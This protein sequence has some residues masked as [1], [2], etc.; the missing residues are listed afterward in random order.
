MPQAV[1]LRYCDGASLSGDKPTP[2]VFQNTTLHF[3]GRAILDAQIKSLLTERGM[4]KASDVVVSGCSAGGL[5]T[6]LHC[7]H[8]AAAIAKATN[9]GGNAGAKVVCMPDAGF[10]LDEDRVPA[11]G[12][13]VLL[14]PSNT[15]AL[16][17]MLGTCNAGLSLVRLASLDNCPFLAA[18]P[19]PAFI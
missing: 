7:D 19:P 13:K 5:A 10:F 14:P 15:V 12:A 8:W 3:R 1:F 6:F 17:A 18:L 4:D 9:N 2:T 11:Y 16:L